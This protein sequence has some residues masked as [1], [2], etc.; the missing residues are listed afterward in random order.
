MLKVSRSIKENQ[1]RIYKMQEKLEKN[2][3]REPTVTELAEELG[4]TPEEIAMASD[5]ATEVESIY[6]PIHRGKERNCSFWTSFRR[7]KTGR[8]EYWTKFFL[9]EVTKY[10]GNEK[11][12]G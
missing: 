2:L 4:M 10:I 1:Y 6:R 8:K 11:K 7:R 3:G 5:A 12:E 9:E